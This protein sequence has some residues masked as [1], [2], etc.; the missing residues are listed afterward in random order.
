ME[1]FKIKS[2]VKIA[3]LTAAALALSIIIAGTIIIIL[4]ANTSE[5]GD[6]KISTR[7]ISEA[8]VMDS[9]SYTI[10]RKYTDYLDESG[11]FAMLID[12]SGNVAWDYNRPDDIP[13]V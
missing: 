4:A 13:D 3:L 12:E 1:D 5:S 2:A 6:Y 8:L 9:K 10:D 11:R 7:E